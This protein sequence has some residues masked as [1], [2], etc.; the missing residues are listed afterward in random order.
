MS[1]STLLSVT[2]CPHYLCPCDGLDYWRVLD[3]LSEVPAECI[4][5]REAHADGG[6]HLHAFCDFGERFYTADPRRFDVDGYHPN[7]Q[8]FGRTPYKGWDYAIKDGDVVCGGLE[9][10]GTGPG[11]D[12]SGAGSQ[13]DRIVG[14]ETP[15]EFWRLIRELAPRTLLTN[16]NSVRAYADWHYRPVV[17]PYESPPEIEFDLSGV[18]ELR[19]WVC[20]NLSRTR[21]PKSLVLYGESRLGKTLWARSLGRHVYNCLQ[22][23]VDDMRGDVEEALYAVF[24]DMQGGFKYFPSYKG[25]LGAQ[26]KFTVTDKYRGKTSVIWGRPTIWLCNES[27]RDFTDVDMTWLEA[28]CVFVE[29]TNPIFRAN[30]E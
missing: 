20:N 17:A 19:E 10:P 18:E 8:P 7:V 25:W 11:T 16:F 27:P 24:D 30:I 6:T 13:W 4:I 26:S 14:A 12:V 28:N 9:R 5:G 23:N 21:R 29:V 3:H 1:N 15:D 2:L 22:F